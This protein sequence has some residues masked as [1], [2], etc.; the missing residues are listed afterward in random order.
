M[1]G[2]GAVAENESHFKLRDDLSGQWRMWSG[3]ANVSRSSWSTNDVDF[4]LYNIFHLTQSSLLIAACLLVLY[5][6]ALTKALT[7]RQNMTVSNSILSDVFIGITGIASSFILSGP[8]PNTAFNDVACK[9]TMGINTVLFSWT[10]WAVTL[11]ALDCY[12]AVAHPLVP[13]ISTKHFVIAMIFV[14]RESVLFAAIPYN[15]GKLYY[16]LKALPYDNSTAICGSETELVNKVEAVLYF[17][18]NWLLPTAL[19][20]S[21]LTRT[22]M[23]SVA[24][25]SVPRYAAPVPRRFYRSRAFKYMVT[26]ITVKVCLGAPF[27]IVLFLRR[28]EISYPI[29]VFYGSLIVSKCNYLLTCF[30]YFM[31]M[32]NVRVRV[33]VLLCG[34]TQNCRRRNEAAAPTLTVHLQTTGEEDDR[35]IPSSQ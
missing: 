7:K 18:V 26:L 14:W 17:T 19:T 8:V 13:K 2:I 27:V 34:L 4:A 33:T 1:S 29:R 5:S 25:R 21:L 23:K 28:L 30:F 15:N 11:M 35:V 22:V 31:W 9:I 3:Y 16:G 20:V 32:R 24:R 6:L 10:A 12:D